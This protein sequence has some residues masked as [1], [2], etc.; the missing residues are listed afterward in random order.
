MSSVFLLHQKYVTSHILSTLVGVGGG[1]WGVCPL[2]P[3]FTYNSNGM[4]KKMKHSKQD[5]IEIKWPKS[6][7]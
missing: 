7:E 4:M 2:S 5:T 6:V 1:G 3:G